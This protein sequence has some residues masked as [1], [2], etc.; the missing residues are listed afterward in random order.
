MKKDV[1]AGLKPA[2]T[3]AKTRRVA[4]REID[5]IPLRRGVDA[6]SKLVAELIEQTP[7]VNKYEGDPGK[8]IKQ[9]NEIFLGR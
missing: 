6:D 4:L 7:H 8:Q 1:R 3:R 2:P 5:K 9:F